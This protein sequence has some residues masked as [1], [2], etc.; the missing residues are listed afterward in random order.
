MQTGPMAEAILLGTV[1]VRVPGQT[2]EWD[3]PNLRIPNSADA[4]RLLRR[5]YRKGWAVE[6]L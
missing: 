6:G 5:T 4:Q 2:L 1:A 3:A